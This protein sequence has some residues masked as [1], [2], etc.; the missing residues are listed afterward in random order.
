MKEFFKKFKKDFNY[1]CALAI[2]FSALGWIV[3]NTF[4]V[5]ANGKIDNRFHILPFIPVYGF[6]SF[7]VYILG[8]P[9]DEKFFGY[10]ITKNKVA[11]NIIYI[12]TLAFFVT[13]GELI[14]GNTIEYL[15]GAKLWNYNNIPLHW[16]RYT[17]L[18]TTVGFSVGGY[19]I[20]KI[21]YYPFLN[22][23]KENFTSRQLIGATIFYVILLADMVY[24][25]IITG[26]KGKGQVYW[27][28]NLRNG[29][30]NILTIIDIVI[31]GVFNVYLVLFIIA[32]MRYFSRKKTTI[33]KKKEKVYISLLLY[34]NGDGDFT[35]TF[36]SINSCDYPLDKLDIY[37]V[38]TKDVKNNL[39]FK[40]KNIIKDDASN[41][42]DAGLKEI[43]NSNNAYDSL[44]VLSSTDIIDI[45]FFLRMSD[46]ICEG[47]DVVASNKNNINYY[48]S[49]L[50]S[51]IKIMELS[52]NYINDCKNYLGEA[53]ILNETGYAIKYDVIKKEGSWPFGENIIDSE[54]INY[55][56]RNKLKSCYQHKAIFYSIYEPKNMQEFV[57]YNTI[58]MEEE[59][60]ITAKKQK[61]TFASTITYGLVLHFVFF[62]AYNLLLTIFGLFLDI[63]SKETLRYAIIALVVYYVVMF[64]FALIVLLMNRRERKSMKGIL[65]EALFHPIFIS[66]Y[67][68]SY[69]KAYLK[70]RKNKKNNPVEK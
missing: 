51:S 18:P 29:N 37:I 22:Y 56:R 38:S 49:N 2:V 3:E 62:V 45:N 10:K 39:K 24:M 52:T 54:I 55:V 66:L 1:I 42:Y 11:A 19:L 67:L 59:L 40:T 7:A 63:K 33:S 65:K 32:N 50:A 4:R 61:K 12:L 5:I 68:L 46:A 23:L 53:N 58:R 48:K 30:I 41:F 9:D 26:I 70:Y 15:C 28:V 20:L 64:L 27:Q 21:F 17:S 16:T 44:I 57:E 34:E 13:F 25:L 36:E 31:F 6:I 43:F 35:K 8:S 60:K 47:Y 69:V 14:V